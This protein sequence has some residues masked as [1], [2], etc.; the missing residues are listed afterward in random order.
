MGVTASKQ[1]NPNQHLCLCD[2]KH[3][4]Y[5]QYGMGYSYNAV[6]MSWYS[7]PSATD[8]PFKENDKISMV[9][10][11]CAGKLTFFIND[12]DEINATKRVGS[13]LKSTDTKYRMFVAL[14]DK[15]DSVKILNF[16]SK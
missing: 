1:K 4:S 14:Y 2:A 9:L 11:L 6:N 8:P 16:F 7:A 15:D 12:K 3:V 5:A 13:I 10:D